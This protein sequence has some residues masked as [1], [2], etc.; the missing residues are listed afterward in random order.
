MKL[1]LLS[2]EPFLEFDFDN[3]QC[4]V[5]PLP[6]VQAREVA[7]KLLGIISRSMREAAMSGVRT[8][9]QLEFV[10]STNMLEHVANANMLEWLTTKFAPMT[11]IE[12]QNGSGTF[13]RL[14]IGQQ[15][16]LYFSGSEGMARW[17]RWLS[18]CIEVNC[19]GFFAELQRQSAL[20]K[21]KLGMATTGATE[22]TTPRKTGESPS[23]SS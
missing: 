14:N 13:V 12:E 17:I 15:Q 6:P 21:T 9:A 4:N 8:P 7:T 22:T 16:A 11:E 18:F 3:R 23:P 20:H 5:F 1:D 2:A 10:G 19:G